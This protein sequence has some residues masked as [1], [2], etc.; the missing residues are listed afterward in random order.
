[1]A[2][3][4]AAPPAAAA[5]E[6]A[7]PAAA[8]AAEAAAAEPSLTAAGI[9]V[10]SSSPRETA[11][12]HSSLE[13]ASE[14]RFPVSLSSTQGVTPGDRRRGPLGAPSSGGPLAVVSSQE[15]APAAGLQLQAEAEGPPPSR[16]GFVRRWWGS[17]GAPGP[18]PPPADGEGPSVAAAAAAWAPT[19]VGRV[20]L[21]HYSGVILTVFVL[22]PV[23]LG[24]HILTPEVVSLP[25][26]LLPAGTGLSQ[27]LAVPDG[28]GCC[29][30]SFSRRNSAAWIASS[31]TK[32]KA[33]VCFFL[34]API[35]C[36]VVFMLNQGWAAHLSLLPFG[37]VLLFVW[38]RLWC[39]FFLCV[40]IHLELILS[41][42]YIFTVPYAGSSSWFVCVV[43]A[44]AI[45]LFPAA[46][47]WT[48]KA[49][50]ARAAAG[51]SV[52]PPER[53]VLHPSRLLQ[54]LMGMCCCWALA[55]VLLMVNLFFLHFPVSRL[56]ED[57]TT[58]KGFL[59][60]AAAASAADPREE[61]LLI[62]RHLKVE[63]VLL[64]TAAF[65]AAACGLCL[66]LTALQWSKVP[67][68]AAAAAAD[69]QGG[70]LGRPGAPFLLGA[71]PNR[72]AANRQNPRRCPSAEHK[73]K[74]DFVT[75]NLHI[76]KVEEG[77]FSLSDGCSIC[78]DAIREG[79]EAVRLPA[80]GHGFHWLCLSCWFSRRFTCPNC[81]VDVYQEILRGLDITDDLVLLPRTGNS[82]LPPRSRPQQPAA[83]AATTATRPAARV[84]P[85]P[86]SAAAAATAGERIA[87]NPAPRQQ[88]RQQLYADTHADITSGW[89]DVEL[90]PTTIGAQP[91]NA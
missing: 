49:F 59:P 83:A 4:A 11:A 69:A 72:L 48:S 31:A 9:Q 25:V 42:A 24:A 85:G 15:W 23:L 30:F 60:A 16:R 54:S 68:H 37:A 13:G 77:R 70:A 71:D 27:A 28:S 81:Q 7:G 86:P 39:I 61:L 53:S 62:Q 6:A 34:A 43:F 40:Q 80:C 76:E 55:D 46:V 51:L 79:E 73:A 38:P 1:M 87:A 84:P 47:Y 21:L 52:R 2:N 41:N 18:P 66:L 12:G 58:L 64:A 44:A 20:H 36:V 29:C 5:A 57:L 45:C 22:L 10:S 90:G 17:R 63:R 65:A 8:G 50:L 3:L 91:R 26:L 35:L 56:P 75:A 89:V 88:Q 14:G 32:F 78:Q 82:M 19:E 33:V 67:L 74:L